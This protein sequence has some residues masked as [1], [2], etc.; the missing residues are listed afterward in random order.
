MSSLN[1]LP[2]VPTNLPHSPP[3]ALPPSPTSGTVWT[4]RVNTAPLAV[5]LVRLHGLWQMGG[6]SE[7]VGRHRHTPGVS[8]KQ[9]LTYRSTAAA[10]GAVAALGLGACADPS[11]PATNDAVDSSNQASPT[12]TDPSVDQPEYLKRVSFTVTNKTADPVEVEN[13]TVGSTGDKPCAPQQTLNKGES[14][15]ILCPRNGIPLPGFYYNTTG[16]T[17][18]TFQT[19]NGPVNQVIAGNPVVGEPQIGIQLG[20]AVPSP[21]DPSPMSFWDLPENGVAKV[22]KFGHEYK[23]ERAPDSNF[24]NMSLTILG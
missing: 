13:K 21:W 22:S 17:K 14:M 18:L 23:L 10:I 24:K 5:G 4:S 12:Q 3:I 11:P 20:T 19:G 15:K 6:Y 2:A 7:P 8:I 9:T 1:R 16:P